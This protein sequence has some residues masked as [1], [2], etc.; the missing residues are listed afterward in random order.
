MIL[1][2][3]NKIFLR[4]T[5]AVVC[6]SAFPM[7]VVGCYFVHIP[8][9]MERLNIGERDLGIAILVFGIFFLI[10]NQFSARFL[11]PRIGTK[12]VMSF[13]MIL[14]S[15]ATVLLVTVPNYQ[16]FL[17]CSIPAG[18][19]WGSSGPIGGIHAQ[20]IEQHFKKIIT[21]YYAMGFNI[22][23]FF[24]SLLA[25]YFLNSNFA[26]WKI[27][28]TLALVSIAVSVIIYNF[29]LPKELDYK[30]V[31]EKYKI[32]EKKVLIFGF[33]LF[34][35]FGSGGIIV[36]WSPLWLTKELGAPLYLGGLGL[37]FYSLGGIFANLF[38]NQLIAIFNEKIIAS[39]FGII[40]SLILFFSI[41]TMN[42]YIIM[43]SFLLYGFFVG[44]LVP[45]AIRQAVIQSSESIPTTVSN[46]ITI[47]FSALLF[48]PAIIGFIA[49]TYSLTTNMYALCFFVF[50]AGAIMFAN[51][52]N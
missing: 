31:G 40:G 5:L 49:E 46:I 17:I 7:I 39:I 41:L 8:W 47:G 34:V 15:F 11:V 45:L 19:G 2:N 22:G 13:A 44:N 30:G 18:L 9:N 48:A 43:I 37:I 52:K 25:A 14:I 51:F 35:V 36:D 6:C 29:S 33:V 10:S 4:A 12:I 28:F 26:P 24:G 21:P 3:N 32:P 23:I 38:S 50:F 20:L 42:I 27:F 16:L 1:T